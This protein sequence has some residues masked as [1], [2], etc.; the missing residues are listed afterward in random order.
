MLANVGKT[1]RQ[2]PSRSQTGQETTNN[3]KRVQIKIYT[4]NTQG[5]FTKSHLQ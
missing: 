2:F 4:Y 3:G 5:L 1:P